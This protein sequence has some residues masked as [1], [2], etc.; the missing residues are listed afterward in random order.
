MTNSRIVVVAFSNPSSM[1]PAPAD[2]TT[3]SAA[4]RLPILG[5][6]Y[7]PM[8]PRYLWGRDF[9]FDYGHIREFFSD[10][11]VLRRLVDLD[12]ASGHSMAMGHIV[13]WLWAVWLY[14]RHIREVTLNLQEIEHEAVTLS[15]SKALDRI[16]NGRAGVARLRKYLVETKQA[17]SDRVGFAEDAYAKAAERQKALELSSEGLDSESTQQT[18]KGPS[19]TPR[20]LA[21]SSIEEEYAWLD[22]QAA[23]LM[24]R[25]N[26]N[27]QVVIATINLEQSQVALKDA[28]VSRRNGKKSTRLTLLAAIYLPLTLATGIFGMN[29]KDI[30]G[31]EV[32]Y[33][34]PIIIAIV[35]ITPSVLVIA[36]IHWRSRF[37]RRLRE[38]IEKWEKEKEA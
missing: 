32:R 30:N 17:I 38:A 5:P 10:I 33:W 22:K 6:K 3:S 37:D 34:W 4:I 16:K 12:A 11:W 13:L 35:L 24:P 31:D 2:F 9:W 28:E 36:F 23:D 19:L 20:Q 29:I 26:E 25:L 18:A 1:N 15:T 27:L 14:E 7:D 21:A 8:Q